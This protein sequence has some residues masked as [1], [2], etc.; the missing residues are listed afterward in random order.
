MSSWYVSK[1]I[2]A[3]RPVKSE[4][5][6]DIVRDLGS[7]CWLDTGM[8]RPTN[9]PKL[10]GKKLT[11]LIKTLSRRKGKAVPN[12][13]ESLPLL[14][15]PDFVLENI[16]LQAHPITAL[17]LGATC[18][19][20]HAEVRRHHSDICMKLLLQPENRVQ[21]TAHSEAKSKSSLP[22]VPSLGT[23]LTQR[24]FTYQLVV[25][26][27]WTVRSAEVLL[28]MLLTQQGVQVHLTW[29]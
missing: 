10:T 24:A 3:F 28:Q 1:L 15:L 4:S 14:Q 17:A 11:S 20:L 27:Q 29:F 5:K 18:K 9:K 2:S 23:Y 21:I 13:T 7:P 22:K 25:R 12:Q 19:Q 8:A 6:R 26:N 16:L